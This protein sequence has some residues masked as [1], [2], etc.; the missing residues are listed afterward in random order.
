MFKFISKFADPRYD[1]EVDDDT[2]KSLNAAVLD[3]G[4]A[5][6][7]SI[8]YENASTNFSA[9]TPK[10]LNKRRTIAALAYANGKI[11]EVGFNAGHS[12][13][14][15]LSSREHLSL[16]SIDICSHRYT[17]KCSKII[18]DRYPSFKFIEGNSPNVLLHDT[19]F[20]KYELV[21]IDGDHSPAGADLDIGIT[22]EKAKPGTRILIDDTELGY[23][24]ALCWQYCMQGKL[25]PLQ[26]RFDF[27]NSFDQLLF[28]KR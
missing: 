1:P 3:A 18:S 13:L 20:E 5:F 16:T 14:L 9:P 7:G 25:I 11:L 27:V 21:V 15:M 2:L 4:E 24:R 6:E 26:D 19:D 17:K 23:L 22:I 8:Y 28:I 12:A 10:Y